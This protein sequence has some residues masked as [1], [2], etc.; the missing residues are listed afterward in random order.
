MKQTEKG[1]RITKPEIAA[2]LAFACDDPARSNLYGVQLMVTDSHVRARATNGHIAIDAVGQN[3]TG[4]ANE[5]F[6]HRDFLKGAMKVLDGKSTLILQ[7]RGAS[8]HDA[9][10]EN[11][12]GVEMSMFSWP[13]DAA[14]SQ[15]SFPDSAAFEELLEAPKGK[16]VKCVTLNADYLSLM[17]KVSKA[18]GVAGISCYQPPKALERVVFRCEGTDTAWIAVVMPMAAGDSEADDAAE[19]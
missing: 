12:D 5:W 9:A 14:N 7:F 11:E 6:V 3:E 15:M 2:L 8:L 19:A 17:G 4:D 1:L 10:V 18:A 16:P 13:H